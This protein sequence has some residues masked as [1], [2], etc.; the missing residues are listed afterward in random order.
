MTRARVNKRAV[1]KA[2]EGSH[3]IIS[4]IAKRLGV[5]RVTVRNYLNK[6]PELEEK[7]EAE[8]EN[9]L[10]FAE[11]KL[12][13]K[14]HEEEAWAIR[15]LL[16]TQ[17]RGRGY[18]KEAGNPATYHGHNNFRDCPPPAWFDTLDGQR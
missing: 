10:D 18:G 5:S 8:R 15:Y 6:Y 7:L 1:E 3:A 13:K 14:I 11:S 12:I 9:V 16:T 17:G 2:I 4:T